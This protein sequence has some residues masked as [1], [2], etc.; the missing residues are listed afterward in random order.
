MLLA[1]LL[2]S[3]PAHAAEEQQSW[4]DHTLATCRQ[5]FDEERC[6]DPEFLEEH[7]HVRTLQIAHR[8]AIRTRQEERR[9][10][11]ELSLQYLCGQNP[12]KYCEADTSGTCVPQMQRIC[13]DLRTRAEQCA[14]QARQFCEQNPADDCLSQRTRYCPSAKKQKIPELLAKYPKLSPE[15]KKRLAL[16]ANQL[17]EKNSGLIDRLFGWLGF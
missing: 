2:L 15:Q 14:Q 7:Y 8:A 1:A 10:L 12:D 16:F 6:S 13:L 5:D 4:L 9:A 11:Q 3:A 17:Q